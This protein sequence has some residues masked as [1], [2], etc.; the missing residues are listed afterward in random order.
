M[1]AATA[2]RN[3]VDER[4]EAYAL[5]ERLGE[6]GQGTIYLAGDGKLAVKLL[7]S[8]RAPGRREALARQIAFVRRLPLDRL[9]IAS[10][11]AT[12]RAPD[13]GYVMDFAS[14][15]EPLVGLMHPPRGTRDLAAWYRETGGLKR[16]LRVLF[17]I[18][19]AFA[20]L[21]GQALIYG[22]PSP[23]NLFVSR[24]VQAGRVFF[25]DADNLSYVSGAPSGVFTPMYGAPELVR[26]EAGTSLATDLHAFAVLA[27]ESLAIAHPLLGD[28]ILDGEPELEEEAL[29]G[30]LP[31][32]EHARD[33]RN[34]SR[35]G[36]ADRSR[37]IAPRLHALFRD[38][39]EEGL[40][41]PA[42][43][44]AAAAWVEVLGSSLDLLVDCSDSTCG[45]AYYAPFP[46]CP[47]C[48]GRRP[49]LLVLAL[50]PYDQVAP[51]TPELGLVNLGKSALHTLVAADRTT[52]VV[53]DRV[54]HGLEGAPGDQPYMGIRLENGRL[55]LRT[56]PNERVWLETNS[57]E[58]P[59]ELS[60]ETVEVA[61]PRSREVYRLHFGPFDRP[62]RVA[63]LSVSG[64]A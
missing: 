9:P 14:G 56:R 64:G 60:A 61:A 59:R 46:T 41:D 42:A 25:I 32:I 6:G 50:H 34:S 17:Q 3:V 55:R 63:L 51:E 49:P 7:R 15:M 29:A 23:K 24:D 21:H 22:D 8:S 44:P 11:H 19:R 47:W 12:L 26:G 27:F 18:A 48:G 38:A 58:R 10:P 40:V 33:P 37:V 5:G 35:F 13:L 54:A 1:T 62:H 39:F 2:T 31:W 28:M 57:T 36:I 52:L 16:R 30:R 4:G 20:D 43:R 45:H 53:P